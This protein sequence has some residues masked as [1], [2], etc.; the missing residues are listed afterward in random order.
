MP[1]IASEPMTST[2]EGAYDAPHCVVRGQATGARFSPAGFSLWRVVGTLAEGTELEWGAVHGDEAL[3]LLGG[4]VDVEGRRAEAE[5][6]VIVEA[7]VEA[8]VRAV[9]DTRVVH[10]G[11]ASPAPPT[12][13]LLGPAQEQGRGVHVVAMQD[14][15][16]VRRGALMP[17]AAFFSDGTRATSR[18]AFFLYG[19]L[20]APVTEPYTAASH[21]HSEDEIIHVL[22]GTLQVGPVRI[23]AGMSV[24]IPEGVRYGFRTSGR[25]RFLN[26][27]RDVALYTTTPGSAPALETVAELRNRPTAVD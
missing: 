16:R 13:G 26:Y 19:Y 20:D 11:P 1:A 25:F 2:I 18:I 10:V 12:D 9:E 4:A 3:Y 5:S 6:A 8:V 27:R 14:A 7:G 24:A 15:A 17:G 23:D 21:L 22:E